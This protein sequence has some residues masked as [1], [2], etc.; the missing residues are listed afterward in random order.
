MGK[1]S[2]NIGQ[3]KKTHTINRQNLNAEEEADKI[4]KKREEKIIQLKYQF[5]NKKIFYK[6]NR[7]MNEILENFIKSNINLQYYLMTEITVINSFLNTIFCKMFNDKISNN[8]KYI[9]ERKLEK[10]KKENSSNK[11]NNEIDTLNRIIKY[12]G[13][14]LDYF[15]TTIPEIIKESYSNNEYKE[16][17]E[18]ILNL[19]YVIFLKINF[20]KNDIAISHIIKIITEL[21][22]FIQHPKENHIYNNLENI[23]K[24]FITLLPNDR[25]DMLY[26]EIKK[27][28]KEKQITN[29]LKEIKEQYKKQYKEE[30]EKLYS[31]YLSKD[32]VKA[33]IE[34]LKKKGKDKN[35]FFIKKFRERKRILQGQIKN[36]DKKIKNLPWK[37]SFEKYR[38]NYNTFF[39]LEDEKKSNFPKI[40]TFKKIYNFISESNINNI[41]KYLICS[42]SNIKNYSKR[43]DKNKLIQFKYIEDFYYTNLKIN[44]LIN[45]Q[46]EII[47]NKFKNNDKIYN[48]IE[49]KFIDEDLRNIRNNINHCKL[50][51]FIINTN[52]KYE[53]KEEEIK[54]IAEKLKK[55]NFDINEKDINN[56]TKYRKEYISN[57]K[58][59]A[60]YLK[61]I[62]LEAKKSKNNEENIKYINCYN[63]FFIE[64]RTILY[65]LKLPYIY[66]KEFNTLK[67]SNTVKLRKYIKNKEYIIDDNIILSNIANKLFFSKEFIDKMIKYDEFNNRLK[68]INRFNKK[69]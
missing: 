6:E 1:T 2:K 9:A 12:N 26:N 65:N 19:E 58:T 55:L 61:E 32:S 25:I 4:N 50:F 59:I 23:F 40:T 35:K 8:F 11:T 68:K 62:S 45:K 39:E 13:G 7:K 27:Y 18:N 36:K 33:E 29:N 10:I 53:F 41:E 22:H 57:V 15:N 42:I 48:F 52:K 20:P 30:I 44:L 14:Y 37:G 38:K 43:L 24:S 60:K 49:D 46:L 56:F 54:E 5:N 3:Y 63:D 69:I 31:E 16:K 17:L 64:Y 34:R 28:D 51:C 66:N 47:K 21:R 67:V